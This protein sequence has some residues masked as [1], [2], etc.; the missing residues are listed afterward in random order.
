[1]DTREKKTLCENISVLTSEIA[2]FIRTE[3]KRFT[4]DKIEYK[5]HNNMVSY[6]DKT[7]EAMITKKLK[8]LLPE[9]DIIAEEGTYSDNGYKYRWIIDPLDGTT[10]F[11]H[12]F[13]PYCISIA[14]QENNET[15][16]GVIREVTTGDLYQSWG[17]G[18]YLNGEKISVSI[19]DKLEDSLGL[20]GL[21]YNMSEN[22]KRSFITLFDYFNRNTHG[23]RRTGSA[24]MNLAFIAKGSADFFYQAN[25]SPWDVAAGAFLVK[26]AGG[27]VTDF[28]GGQDY[29]FGRTIIATNK[30]LYNEILKTIHE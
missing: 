2:D 21:A 6:V 11:I 7:S 12:N 25:L 13:A 28:Q 16:I 9:S 10:N 19:I 17:E 18:A 23:A 30:Y 8:E 24:A 3:R 1:M 22:Q 20:T 15:I 27:T 26:Q 4:P 29:I 5:G 14:L